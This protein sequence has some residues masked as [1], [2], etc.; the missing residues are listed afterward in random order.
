MKRTIP[1]LA[2]SAL[3]VGLLAGCGTSSSADDAGGGKSAAGKKIVMLLNDQ[4]DPYYL[5]LV[6]GAEAEAKKQGFDFSWQAPST[7]DVASQTQLLQS[8]AARKPD[9]IIMSAL[10]AKAMIAPMKQVM[11]QGIPII[12][13]DADVADQSARLATV[14]S[15]GEAAGRLAAETMDKL[16]G[17]KGKVAFEGYT[18]GT[19]STDARL[20]G[21]QEGL[22][23][24][25]LEYVAERYD[26]TD[27]TTIA[28]TVSAVLKRYPDLAGIFTN[29][30]NPTLGAAQAVQ[31]AGK[32][33]QVKI[34]GFDASPDEV[35][36]LKRGLVS[37][38]IIQKPGE[39][40][41]RAVSDLAA[42]LK[43]G[44][45]PQSVSLDAV[46]ATKENMNDPAVSAY[47][48]KAG[49]Q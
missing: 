1:V 20:K 31:A 34:V 19:S 49:K 36:L 9:G 44:T 22:K 35:S 21:W 47:F 41:V 16:L 42:Y 2:A 25:G 11:A 40:G 46:V 28:G 45:K 14:T 3:A 30:T 43:D 29:W 33:D 27:L 6:A 17:G 39:M 48:Y 18:P 10:D 4:F 12:T 32:S 5:T 37:A 24:T 26:A 38:L 15:D 7:L 8:V 13:V 23:Q